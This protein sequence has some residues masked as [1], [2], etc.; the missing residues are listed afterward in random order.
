MKT[1]LLFV[2]SGIAAILAVSSQA[3]AAVTVIGNGLG[4]DCY[5]AAEF[6]G[7]PAKALQTCTLAIEQESLNLSDR[8]ATYINRGIVRSRT[9]DAQ[10]ALKDY[11]FGLSL[12][13]AHPEGYVDRGATY[14]ALQ[15]YDDAMVDIDRGIELGAKKLQIAYYASRVS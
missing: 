12:D 6:G 15:R 11:N 7:D 2:I 13:G 14:I 10:G 4:A 1:G 8:A 5:Q 9:G 3:N